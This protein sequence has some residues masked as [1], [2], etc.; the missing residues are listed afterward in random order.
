MQGDSQ[1]SLSTLLLLTL[2]AHA[3]PVAGVEGGRTLS[4]GGKTLKLSGAGIRKKVF[5]KVYVGALYLGKRDRSQR[6]P[7]GRQRP[8]RAYGLPAQRRQSQDS[9]RLQRGFE[10]NSGDK[11][12][13]LQARLGKVGFRDQRR[14]RGHR[15]HDQLRPWQGHHR[16]RPGRR[17]GHRRGQ[18][19]RRCHVPDLARPEASRRRPKERPARRQVASLTPCPSASGRAARHA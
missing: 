12:A 15:D 10:N 16:R 5:I 8:R 9:R 11:M 3:R 18:R 17:L 2:S 4:V 1:S 7:Q 13:A 19:L 6:H 14:Q